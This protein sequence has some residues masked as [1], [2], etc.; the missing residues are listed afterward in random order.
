MSRS[1]HKE[2]DFSAKLR[3]SSV[4]EGFKS[5]VNWQRSLRGNGMLCPAPAMAPVS[6][7][8]DLTTACNFDC[9]HCVD[10][11]I[12]NTGGYL[13]LD[14]VKKSLDTLKAHGLLSV[15]LL[16]GGEPT[17]YKDF[18]EVVR[19]IKGQGL[20]LGIVTN[21]SRLERVAEIAD[22]LGAHDWLRLS[23]DSASQDTFEK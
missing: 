16:G 23:I 14:G 22:L 20:Q 1:K 6:I 2:H 4:I 5:Y 15:I 11:D 9:P 21:G 3:Q 7:N 10:S 13:G 8:L 12:I 18:A 17:L 19:Y